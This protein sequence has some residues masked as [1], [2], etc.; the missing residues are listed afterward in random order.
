M[1]L[2]VVNVSDEVVMDGIV[3]VDVV[4]EVDGFMTLTLKVR[5]KIGFHLRWSR[6][7]VRNFVSKTFLDYLE[8]KFVDG[9][10]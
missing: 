1:D 9:Q 10:V 2:A 4:A 8:S 6:G 5:W 7:I 3:S